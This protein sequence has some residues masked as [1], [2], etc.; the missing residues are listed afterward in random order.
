MFTPP[1]PSLAVDR[2]SGRAV[3]RLPGRPRS[4]TPTCWLWS[5]APRRDAAG[6][7][8]CASTTRRAA[9]ARRSTCPS[10]PSRPNGRLDVLYYDRRADRDERAQRGLAAVLLRRRQELHCRASSSPTARSARGSA[11][12]L[13]R[14]PAGP[15]Q[16]PRAAVRPT[17][18]ATACGPTRA[19]AACGPASRTSHAGSSRSTTRRGSRTPPKRRCG[20]AESSSILARHRGGVSRTRQAPRRTA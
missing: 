16:P 14:E 3:R 5:L 15:R 9:T 2:D 8:P 12:A 20:S 11:S 10:S 17:A 18:R 13:E 7:R 4:A 1:Y 19:P 6:P